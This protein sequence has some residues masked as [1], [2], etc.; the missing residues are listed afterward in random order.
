[1]KTNLQKLVIQ[2]ITDIFQPLLK[3]APDAVLTADFFHT[4]GWDIDA[5]LNGDLT[6]LT[7]VFAAVEQQI[8]QVE[9]VVGAANAPGV[10]SFSALRTALQATKGVGQALQQLTTV[11]LAGN[12]A[13]SFYL[14]VLQK[15]V[16]IYLL[17][18]QGRLY[19]FFAVTGIIVPEVT[20]IQQNGRYVKYV[21]QVPLFSFDRLLDFLKS[22]KQRVAAEYWPNGVADFATTNSTS[23][24]A[25]K[26]LPRLTNFLTSLGLPATMAN[27]D[28]PGIALSVE[29]TEAL[30]SA[31]TLSKVLPLPGQGTL[32]LGAY[33]GLLSAQ[34]QGPGVFITPYGAADFETHLGEWLVQLQLA[35]NIGTL[36]LKEDAVTL[37]GNGLSPEGGIRLVVSKPGD[38]TPGLG[39]QQG[40]RLQLG[41]IQ[42][43]IGLAFTATSHIIDAYASLAESILTIHPDEGD[44]FLNKVIPAEGLNVKFNALLGWSSAKGLY[45]G[46]R[47][48]LKNT[49]VC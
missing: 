13:N 1:M 46:G 29:E 26:L 43:G 33:V 4:L 38:N 25:Q 5:L 18:Q 31:I 44:S 34:N 21:S 9:Q 14:D 3:V 23:I 6:P 15:L 41:T 19:E 16:T 36:V 12:L 37:L 39:N 49:V 8:G 2:G 17:T 47:V 42:A 20:T 7:T 11:N 30:K 35:S 45:F 48:G 10:E 40:T 24:V 22:P 32:Q 28:M 27:A